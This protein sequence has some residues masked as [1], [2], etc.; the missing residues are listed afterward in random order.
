MSD[1][2]VIAFG[3]GLP[4]PILARRI[5]W[6]E[7]PLFITRPKKQRRCDWNTCSWILWFILVIAMIGKAIHAKVNGYGYWAPKRKR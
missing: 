5:K 1:D 3:R 4:G 6:Y 7:D 2:N